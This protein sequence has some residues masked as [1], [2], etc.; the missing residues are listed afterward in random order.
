[1]LHNQRRKLADR[2]ARE[3]AGESFWSESFE[4]PLRVKLI[5]LIDQLPG[6]S[7]FTLGA[8]KA[9]LFD[10]G[11][12]FLHD[13]QYNDE[14][15]FSQYVLHADDEMI[16]TVIEAW[17]QASNRPQ[18]QSQ[19][20]AWDSGALFDQTVNGLLVRHRV[21]FE[22]IDHEM[23]PFASRELHVAVIAPTLS[24]VHGDDRWSKVEDSFRAALAEISRG[25]AANAITD[26]GTALQETLVLLGCKGNALGPLISSAK[27]A[28]ILA[29]HDTPLLDAIERAAHWAS[30]DRSA[31]GDAHNAK[32]AAPDDAWLTVHIV[33]ALILRLSKSSN[34]A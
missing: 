8:R 2:D 31:M 26:A 13:S 27:S 20:G 25:E 24:L 34:R 15:D 5:Q 12:F 1:M 4:L 28:G 21:S 10:E 14:L 23:V 9:I 32:S 17:S 11:T 19:A 30:A 6:R 18:L 29:A 16:P 3:A 22:L 7:V 33:G